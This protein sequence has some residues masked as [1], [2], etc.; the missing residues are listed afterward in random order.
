MQLPLAQVLNTQVTIVAYVSAA[1]FCMPPMVIFDKGLVPELTEGEVEGTLY[2][3]SAKGWMD[4]E[5]F[6]LWF[7]N[8]FLSYIPSVRPTLLLMDGHSSHHCPSTIRLAAQE[9][10]ILFALPEHN[11][12]VSTLGQ[13]VFWTPEGSMAGRVS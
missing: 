9:Q 6:G 11:S 4:R 5:L 3:L 8:H 7:K 12:P 1:G 13:G 10:V 2:G